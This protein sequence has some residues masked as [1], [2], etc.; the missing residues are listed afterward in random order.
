VPSSVSLGSDALISSLEFVS[1]LVAVVPF[2][3]A[4]WLPDEPLVPALAVVPPSV[5]GELADE[6]C[7]ALLVV[8]L[9]ELPKRP[10]IKSLTFGSN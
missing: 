7:P 3:G 4:V 5:E 9:L 6:V 8:L 10:P 2:D 1:P